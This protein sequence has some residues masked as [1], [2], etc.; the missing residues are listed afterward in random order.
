MMKFLNGLK[1]VLSK[2]AIEIKIHK[3]TNRI[4]P[5]TIVCTIIGATPKVSAIILAAPLIR[6]G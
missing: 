2:T 1:T 6:R 4:A 3:G 5:H